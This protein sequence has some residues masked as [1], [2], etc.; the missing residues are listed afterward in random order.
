MP[1]HG[2]RPMLSESE[3]VSVR[4]PEERVE[5]CSL[6]QTGSR[7]FG[8][9]PQSA[10]NRIPSPRKCTNKLALTPPCVPETQS[11]GHSV[12]WSDEVCGD[13]WSANCNGL[14]HPHRSLDNSSEWGLHH[15]CVASTARAVGRP[16]AMVR[17]EGF[18]SVARSRISCPPASLPSPA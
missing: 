3:G 6:L 15:V 17:Q 11:H 14:S 7:S 10:E 12:L 16:L 2:T 8:H 5:G 4:V 13:Q 18:V 1:E 9:R